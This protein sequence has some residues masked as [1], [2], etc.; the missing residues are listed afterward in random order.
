MLAFSFIRHQNKLKTMKAA[1]RERSPEGRLLR[2]TRGSKADDGNDISMRITRR[3]TMLLKDKSTLLDTKPLA[4][5]RARQGRTQKS[6]E[7]A[8]TRFSRTSEKA[9]AG[10]EEELITP[11]V[12]KEDPDT[13]KISPTAYPGK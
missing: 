1:K 8:F 3:S 6:S 13:P 10:H 11:V 7:L 2:K 5:R 9:Q 4:I 12:K